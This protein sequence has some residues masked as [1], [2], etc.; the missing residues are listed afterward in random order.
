MDTMDTM[1]KI[2][3][4]SKSGTLSIELRDEYP[5]YTR[6]ASRPQKGRPRIGL[7]FWSTINLW[8]PYWQE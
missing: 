1:D 5:D 8:F 2:L 7:G 3:S 4:D 6:K